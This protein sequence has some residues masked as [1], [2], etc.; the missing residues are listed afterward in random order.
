MRAGR[1][2]ASQGYLPPDSRRLSYFLYPWSQ[3]DVHCFQGPQRHT[4]TQRE[5]RTCLFL[6][7]PAFK[8]VRNS[9]FQ[10]NERSR[11]VSDV[12]LHHWDLGSIERASA[13]FEIGPQ[14]DSNS[15]STSK[16]CPIDK[17]PKLAKEIMALE[18]WSFDRS[19][20]SKLHI[21]LRTAS[22]D[23]PRYLFRAWNENS[24]GDRRL[25]TPQAITPLAFLNNN[26]N[27]KKK[28]TAPADIFTMDPHELRAI[29]R[30][31][32]MG[33]S[34][35][36]TVFSSW[37]HSLPLVLS[38]ANLKPNSYVSVIDTHQLKPSNFIFHCGAPEM[39]DVSLPRFG[40]ELLVF[41]VVEG[42][43][44]SAARADTWNGSTP[45]DMAKKFGAKFGAEF[46]LPMAVQAL[47]MRGRGAHDEEVYDALVEA[48][49]TPSSWEMDVTFPIMGPGRMGYAAE[50][51]AA[52]GAMMY[53]VKRLQETGR[54]PAM[55]GKGG[56]KKKVTFQLD[57]EMDE[58][59]EENPGK[60]DVEDE[61]EEV[62]MGGSAKGGA[63][64]HLAESSRIPRAV[65]ELYIDML[66]FEAHNEAVRG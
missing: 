6:N 28:V 29:I 43:A 63:T 22:S 62:E 64:Q 24:G 7:A 30:A 21:V 19:R 38:I 45:L 17:M 8:P 13:A 5:L 59:D 41:G 42:S 14:L 35:V 27:K 49:S 25:N 58:D 37:S 61:T 4:R 20:S 66:G 15:C 31:H 56:K 11:H 2:P 39:I 46:E 3:A 1:S 40:E 51:T 54:L 44:H 47:T 12:C 48:L 18:D 34:H 50:S 60:I 53:I 16:T 26:I 52:S 65:Y 32:L 57:E 9:H 55:E 23:I 33:H 10:L 36:E